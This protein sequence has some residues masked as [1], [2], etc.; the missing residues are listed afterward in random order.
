MSERDLDA[1]EV[2]RKHMD[3]V[4]ARAHVLYLVAVLGGATLVM[5]MLLVL[6]D[7]LR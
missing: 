7:V 3:G 5:L 2:R 6:L 4:N 1:E